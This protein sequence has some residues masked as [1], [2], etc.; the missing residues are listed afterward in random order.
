VTTPERALAD[1]ILALHRPWYEVAGKRY[2]HTVYVGD[3]DRPSDHVC[4]IG[5][6]DACGPEEHYLLAC[7]ECR[8]TT[9]DGEDGL[10]LW[11]CPTA[12]LVLPAT[13]RYGA[14]EEER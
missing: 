1:A 14:V 10:L 8:Q 4:R 13:S 9:D 6:L 5:G 12:R 2:D 3:A 7:I 11:P